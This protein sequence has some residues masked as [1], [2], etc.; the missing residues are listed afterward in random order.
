M[1]GER[2]NNGGIAWQ[3]VE[4]FE[5]VDVGPSGRKVRERRV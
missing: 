5:S 4:A 2:S 3:R 1:C